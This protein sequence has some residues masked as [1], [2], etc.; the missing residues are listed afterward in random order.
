MIYLRE[1]C[2]EDV[3]IINLWRN[4]IEIIQYLTAPFRYINVE[5]DL[6]WYDN[7]MKCRGNNVRCAICKKDSNKVIGNV[8]LINI[9][10][11]HRKCEFYIIIGEE[12]NQSQG[13][14]FLATSKM[15]EHAFMN[16]NLHRVELSVL[17]D[18]IKAIGLYEKVGFRKEGVLRNAIFKNGIYKNL[19]YMSLL[20]N[21]FSKN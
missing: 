7:Y 20:A 19:I 21:E 14:G 12:N 4:D 6:E 13:I 2:R 1:I 18:N 8:G 17:E 11:I 3:S 9:D 16:L 10:Y 15:I 5:T